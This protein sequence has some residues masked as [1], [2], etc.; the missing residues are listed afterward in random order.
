MSVEDD[1]DVHGADGGMGLGGGDGEAGQEYYGPCSGSVSESNREAE[2]GSGRDDSGEGKDAEEPGARRPSLLRASKKVR[3]DGQMAGK[4]QCGSDEEDDKQNGKKERELQVFGNKAKRSPD[5]D[6]DFPV[7][8]YFDMES[9]LR[10]PLTPDIHIP[11][12][13][14]EPN[15]D[16]FEASDDDRMEE[17]QPESPERVSD[18]IVPSGTETPSEEPEESPSI[19]SM[20]HR[21]LE[22][23]I[24]GTRYQPHLP[25]E[26]CGSDDRD[27][28]GMGVIEPAE[29]KGSTA[30]KVREPRQLNEAGPDAQQQNTAYSPIPFPPSRQLLAV[31]PGKSSNSSS[32]SSTATTPP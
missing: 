3:S 11:P 23:G 18:V 25:H 6:T 24:R 28:R 14:E 22:L 26:D 15:D 12:P 9:Y 4:N 10:L 1:D 27:L 30:Y 16:D 31:G 17:P 8:A 32:S 5:D 20:D 21:A 29:E 19:S 7:D 13:Q 2:A